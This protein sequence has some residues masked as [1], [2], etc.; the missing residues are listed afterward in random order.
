MDYDF[1]EIGTS[2]FHTCIQS[3]GP[4]DYGLS[5]EPIKLYLDRLP[6][7]KN[8]TKINCAISID[9]TAYK[10]KIYWIHPD[11]IRKHK[12]YNFVKGCNKIGEPHTM[13]LEIL[14]YADI[15][16]QVTEVDMIPIAAIFSEYNVS[17]IK[18]LKIDA[19]GCDCDILKTLVPVLKSREKAYY[20]DKIIF[21]ANYLTQPER[22][23]E[24]ITMYEELGYETEKRTSMENVCLSKIN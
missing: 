3:C 18:L 12:L 6:D 14:E 24:T 10:D 2:D 1:I 19:E 5:I 15:T 16:V 4:D 11:D 13:H 9:G 17:K 23:K 8:V 7:K 20:P 22:I 21:E